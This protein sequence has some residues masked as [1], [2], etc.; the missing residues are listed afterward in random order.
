MQVICFATLKELAP[1][2]DQWEQLAGGVPFRSWTWLSH[3][4][5][6]YGPQQDADAGRRRLAVFCVFDD[7]G[8]LAGVAPW[9]LD[10]SAMHGRVL[11]PLGSGEVCSDYLSVL[12]DPATKDLVIEVLADYLIESACGDGPEALPWDLLQLDGIETADHAVAGLVNYLAVSGCTVHRQAA[13]NCWRLELPTDWESYLASLGK[14]LRRDLRRLERELLDTGRAVV[15]AVT[16]LDEL[17]QA[18]DILVELHQR[19]RKMLGE[20]GCFTSPRFLGFYRD[21]VPAMLVHGQVQ[22]FWLELDGK[23]VAAEYQLVGN[24]VLYAYQAGVDPQSMQHQP[25]KLLNLAILRRAIEHGYRA[26][27]FLRGDEPYKARF[28]A[29]SHSNVQWRVVPP[30]AVPRLRHSLWLAK[31]NVKEWIKRG[32]RGERHGASGITTYERRK[33][34]QTS[35]LQSPPPA[36]SPLAPRP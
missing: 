28:G 22:F 16:R 33:E 10:C 2:A 13:A 29:Q 9:Y 30:R 17:A 31:N 21:V 24:G 35:R 4:W 15:H 5:R 18:M 1:Y 6:H 11:R 23:P 25:G 14:N 20:D 3:W 34:V 26:F 32:V 19:R 8:A 27:D 7:A 36:P 12:S